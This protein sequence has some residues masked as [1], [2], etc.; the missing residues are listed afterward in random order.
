MKG[1]VTY[2]VSFPQERKNLW[3]D[4]PECVLQMKMMAEF[5]DARVEI[6][7]GTWFVNIPV[8]MSGHFV[9]SMISTKW[10]AC[11]VTSL[12]SGLPGSRDGLTFGVPEGLEHTADA[13]IAWKATISRDLD[14]LMP[15]NQRD[16]GESSYLDLVQRKGRFERFMTDLADWL[17]A[18]AVQHTETTI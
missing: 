18:G 17:R 11:R 10:G 9:S 16:Y 7:C 12:R 5:E 1:R 6:N 8:W 13:V 14:A 2:V 3:K 4:L 15:R